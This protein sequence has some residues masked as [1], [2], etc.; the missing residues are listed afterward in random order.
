MNLEK[1]WSLTSSKKGSQL[2]QQRHWRTN[3]SSSHQARCM[4]NKAIHM[5]YTAVSWNILSRS[6]KNLLPRR[7]YSITSSTASKGFV[8]HSQRRWCWTMTT[9]RRGVVARFVCSWPTLN[10]EVLGS[11]YSAMLVTQHRQCGTTSPGH[12]KTISRRMPG[13]IAKGKKSRLLYIT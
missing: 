7:S 9:L 10:Q 8:L 4:T 1:R 11:I 3:C 13:S 12:L 2:R 6:W 5:K